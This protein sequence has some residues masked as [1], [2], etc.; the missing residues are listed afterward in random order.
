[1]VGWSGR[2]DQ[3]GL[4]YTDPQGALPLRQEISNLY[5]TV[6]TDD[7]IVAAPQE[8]INMAFHA[9]LRPGDHVVSMFPGYQSLYEIARHIGCDVSFWEPEEQNDG[10]LVFQVTFCAHSAF[11]CADWIIQHAHPTPVSNALRL[12][13]VTRQ[14]NAVRHGIQASNMWLQVQH[15]SK[16]VTSKTRAV[17]VNFPHNPTGALSSK[18]DWAH[19]VQLCKQSNAYLFSDEMYR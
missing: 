7:L 18:A 2:W 4:A 16:L 1:M 14:S 19:I 11:A 9:M 12:C 10:S 8:L 6:S 5:E 3:L 17:V 15:L 13:R